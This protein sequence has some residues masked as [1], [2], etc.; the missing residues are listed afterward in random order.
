MRTK[1]KGILSAAA[2]I[3]ANYLDQGA[4][5]LQLV[6]MT[7]QLTL[8][9]SLMK[10]VGGKTATGKKVIHKIRNLTMEPWMRV[11]YGM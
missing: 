2:S 7:R 9:R 8:M 11:M 10:L 4:R 5:I 1:M 6:T 3:Q